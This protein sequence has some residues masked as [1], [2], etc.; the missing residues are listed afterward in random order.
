MAAFDFNV[1]ERFREDDGILDAAERQAKAE[2]EQHARSTADA[3][4]REGSR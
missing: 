3:P 2:N 4:S 1:L